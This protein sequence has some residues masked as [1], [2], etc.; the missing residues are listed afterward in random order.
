MLQ[1]E[2]ENNLLKTKDISKGIKEDL[3]IK[4][5]NLL[6]AAENEENISKKEEMLEEATKI[7]G[8]DLLTMSIKSYVIFLSI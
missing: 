7:I 8:K 4:A 3:R 5:Q 1:L 2:L 6:I